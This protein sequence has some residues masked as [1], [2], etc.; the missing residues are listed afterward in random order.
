MALDQLR[1]ALLLS[2]SMKN[3]LRL[4]VCLSLVGFAVARVTRATTPKPKAASALKTAAHKPSANKPSGKK[5]N[6]KTLMTD[7]KKALAAMVKAARADKGLD[8]KV[9]KNKPF[10]KSTQQVAKGLKTADKGLA[11]KSNDFFKGIREAR[12]A[13]QQLKVDWQLTDSKNKAVIDNGK[14][15][16]HSLARLRTEF[17]KEAARKKKGGEL[18]AQEKAQFE[19]LKGQQ[20]DLLAKLKKVQ[21]QSQKDKALGKGLKKIESQANRIINEPMNLKTYLATLY[22]LDQQAGLIRGYKYYVDKAW[23]GDYLLLDN[24]VNTYD[25]FYYDWG[26]GVTYDWAYVDTPVDIYEHEDV[27]VT[28]PITDDEITSEE[29]F[30]ENEPVDMSEAEQEEVAAEEDNDAEVDSDDTADDDSMDDGADEEGE[31]ASDDGG[32][33]DDGGGDEDDGG[34]EDGGDDDGGDD[35]GGDD[36]GGDDDGGGDDGD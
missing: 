19:K 10:W 30:A 34:D 23:R 29:S 33:E 26:T 7:S 1:R 2:S 25:T 22:L 18:T 31:E 28:D 4:L 3:L 16:G 13:E 8:P 20:K 36:D 27:E 6:A 11:S 5:A 24:I 17:G 9:P 35:D 32:D 15:L 12:Q 21:G 14:K